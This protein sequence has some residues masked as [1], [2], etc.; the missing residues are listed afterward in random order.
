MQKVRKDLPVV[1]V[2]SRNH[3]M[4]ELGLAIRANM[5]LFAEIPLVALFGLGHFEVTLFLRFLVEAA[6]LMIEASLIVPVL[7]LKAC[8]CRC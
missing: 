4:D 7:I 6:V 3:H 5:R 8:A 1:R 2:Y